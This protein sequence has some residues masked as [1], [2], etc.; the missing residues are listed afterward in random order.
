MPAERRVP[1]DGDPVHTNVGTFV[2]YRLTGVWD[3]A[4]AVKAAKRSAAKSGHR[5]VDV[6]YATEQ[7]D[8]AWAVEVRVASSGGAS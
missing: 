6:S 7:P 1:R 3:R 5:V 8:G 2:R 4:T